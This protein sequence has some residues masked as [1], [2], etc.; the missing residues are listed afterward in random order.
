MQYRDFVLVL[1]AVEFSEGNEP[2]K[3][4]VQV[5]DSMVGQGEEEEFIDLPDTLNASIGELES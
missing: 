4:K 3:I 5:F 2:R 1:R